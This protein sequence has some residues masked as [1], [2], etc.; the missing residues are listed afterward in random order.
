M[1]DLRDV[2]LPERLGCELDTALDAYAAACRDSL[3]AIRYDS[4]IAVGIDHNDPDEESAEFVSLLPFRKRDWAEVDHWI[5]SRGASPREC[6]GEF[7]SPNWAD[8]DGELTVRVPEGA[9][10]VKRRV[11]CEVEAAGILDGP[12][13]FFARLARNLN[14]AALPGPVGPTVAFR[15]NTEFGDSLL[16]EL[17]FAIT[18]DQRKVLRGRGSLGD[19]A[20]NRQ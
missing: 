6:W 20:A 4:I 10:D 14:R 3:A 5:T 15:L 9:V 18:N 16:E 8:A 19:L 2:P 1:S 13:W 11:L 17:H 7:W 12:R